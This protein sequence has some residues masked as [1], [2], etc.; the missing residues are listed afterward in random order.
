MYFQNQVTNYQKILL[1]AVFK[2]FSLGVVLHKNL[3]QK[4]LSLE[5]TNSL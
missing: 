5:I 2:F 3:A 4:M 1:G